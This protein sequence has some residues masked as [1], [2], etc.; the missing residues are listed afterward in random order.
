MYRFTFKTVKS[1][2]FAAED[3]RMIA[4]WL[5][6]VPCCL[7]RGKRQIHIVFPYKRQY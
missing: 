6:S 1:K 2:V 7:R 3:R 4:V 5:T